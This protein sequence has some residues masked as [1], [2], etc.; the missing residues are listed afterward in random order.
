M[1][2]CECLSF[3]FVVFAKFLRIEMGGELVGLVYDLIPC[4]S[5]SVCQT[6]IFFEDE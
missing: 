2:I 6:S 5:S 4:Y 1:L 3:Q